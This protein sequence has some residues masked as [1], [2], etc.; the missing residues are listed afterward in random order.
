MIAKFTSAHKNGYRANLNSPVAVVVHVAE[1]TYAGTIAWFQDPRA[2][3]STHFVVGK[4]ENQVLQMVRYADAAI[5]AGWNKGIWPGYKGVSPNLCT[6]GIE[7]AGRTGEPFTNWQYECN[8][9]IISE[10]AKKFKFDPSPLSILGHCD[11]DQVN[12]KNCPGTGVDMT[13]LIEMAKERMKDAI[14]I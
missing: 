12:R 2:K 5:H 6:I 10:V 7:N 11:M 13:K 9:W 3:V 1:G 8:A 14:I 4:L